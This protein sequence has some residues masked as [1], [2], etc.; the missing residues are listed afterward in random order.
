MARRRLRRRAG[1][2]APPPPP[3]APAPLSERET[4]LAREE[5]AIHGRYGGG[6][7]QAILASRTPERVQTGWGHEEPVERLVE[8]G[9]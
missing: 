8:A 4:T 3:P 1:V 2:V 6:V 5:D 9:R 7:D